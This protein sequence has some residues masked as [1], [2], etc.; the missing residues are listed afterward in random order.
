MLDIVVMFI[1]II[2]MFS[3]VLIYHHNFPLSTSLSK[4]KDEKVS[5]KGDF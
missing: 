4:D 1:K 3:K 5:L 2:L